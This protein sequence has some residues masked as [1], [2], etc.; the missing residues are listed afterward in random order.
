MASFIPSPQEIIGSKCMSILTWC[1]KVALP[2]SRKVRRNWFLNRLPQPMQYRFFKPAWWGGERHRWFTL[3]V[4]VIL[5]SLDNAARGV[6]PPLY[7]VMARH[8]QVSESAMG[9]VSALGILVVAIT[10]VA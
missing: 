10:A 5:A 3:I 6:L 1:K 8:F 9:Y 4:F 2:S 7:A